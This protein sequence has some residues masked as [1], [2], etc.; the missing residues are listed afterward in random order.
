MSK[1]TDYD[2]KGEPIPYIPVAVEKS[3]LPGVDA[4]FGRVLARTMRDGDILKKLEEKN[5]GVSKEIMLLVLRFYSEE[6]LKSL[7]HGNAVSLCGMGVLSPQVE[8][9]ITEQ[10]VAN[11]R[12]LKYTLKFTPSAVALKA[13]KNFRTEF[14]SKSVTEPVIYKIALERTGE[15]LQ[16]ISDS[17]FVCMTGRNLL[18]RKDRHYKSEKSGIFLENLQTKQKFRVECERIISNSNARL[19]FFIPKLPDG[20]YKIF[21]QKASVHSDG[22]EAISK[23]GFMEFVVRGK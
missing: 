17:E 23:S 14:V 9:A 3:N 8:G 1:V 21:V 11:G 7:Q 2:Y 5:I 19:K 18:F 22:M 10:Q 12:G 15:E 6:V 4:K 16:E 13:T 20:E